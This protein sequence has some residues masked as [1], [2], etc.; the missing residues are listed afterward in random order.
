[1]VDFAK[2]H[3]QSKQLSFNQM[4]AQTLSYDNQFDVITSFTCLHLIK[5]TQ[6][7]FNGFAQSLKPEGMILLQ[8]PYAHGLNTPLN[9]LIQSARW[10]PYFSTFST[11]WYFLPPETYKQHLLKARLEPLRVDITQKHEVYASIGEF[12]SL[13]FSLDTACKTSSRAAE[14]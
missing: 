14:K 3:Y 8:F 12:P 4:D 11:P 13:S 5:D 6:A 7:A 9:T 1:M 10:Q 2:K